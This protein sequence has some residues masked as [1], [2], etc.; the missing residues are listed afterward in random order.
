MYITDNKEHDHL[1][2][3]LS[4]VECNEGN[5][6]DISLQFLTV[7]YIDLLLVQLTINILL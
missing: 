7:N 4:N 5:S 1:N 6:G 2:K 3:T